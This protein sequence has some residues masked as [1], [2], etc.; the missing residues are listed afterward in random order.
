MVRRLDAPLLTES[1]QMHIHY[2][3]ER[4]IGITLL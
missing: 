3:C 2:S 4:A 1:E